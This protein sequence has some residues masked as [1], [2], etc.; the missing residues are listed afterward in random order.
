[1]ISG[2]WTARCDY[3]KHWIACAGPVWF[4]S[5]LLLPLQGVLYL[6]MGNLM[7]QPLNWGQCSSNSHTNGNGLHWMDGFH[8]GVK[9]LKWSHAKEPEFEIACSL[10]TTTGTC[11]MT[12]W[13]KPEAILTINENLVGHVGVSYYLCRAHFLGV[14]LRRK[15]EKK[16]HIH[17]TIDWAFFCK[18]KLKFN[19][20]SR[21]FMGSV[22]LLFF[23]CSCVWESQMFYFF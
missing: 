23:W 3:P 5:E 6:V 19:Q 11:S 4:L 7:K 13:V 14:R 20:A 15:H 8:V 1:M 17:R 2:A 9:H 12:L 18:N 16:Q 22:R 10:H 21:I